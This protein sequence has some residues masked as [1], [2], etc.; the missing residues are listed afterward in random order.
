MYAVALFAV[1]FAVA[2]GSGPALAAPPP[3]RPMCDAVGRAVSV[4]WTARRLADVVSPAWPGWHPALV[5]VRYHTRE[6][7]RLVVA[8]DQDPSCPGLPVPARIVGWQKPPERSAIALHKAGDRFWVEL[9]E[10]KDGLALE[11]ELATL[12]HLHFHVHQY[13]HGYPYRDVNPTGNAPD[14]A[15]AWRNVPATEEMAKR[16]GVLAARMVDDGFT[17]EDGMALLVLRRN[18]EAALRSGHPHLPAAVALTEQFEGIAQ[19]VEN[20]VVSLPAAREVMVAAGVDP[21]DLDPVAWRKAALAV[22]PDYP[23]A[24]GYATALALDAAGAPWKDDLLKLGFDELVERSSVA[25]AF[26]KPAPDRMGD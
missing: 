22:G 6:G 21:R 9:V 19:Y 8:A 13:R 25:V 15:W 5:E 10:G 17:A 18:H 24:T 20:Q 4:L 2:L 11:D 26:A 23:A 12:V 16:M 3:T 14:A 7:W 1:A